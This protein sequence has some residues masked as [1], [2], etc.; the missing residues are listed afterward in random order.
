M[1]LPNSTALQRVLNPVVNL[2]P[3][4]NEFL[5][6]KN[7]R[8]HICNLIS[9]CKFPTVLLRVCNRW[10]FTIV[11]QPDFRYIININICNWCAT[12]LQ[13]LLCNCLHR[14]QK[15]SLKSEVWKIKFSSMSAVINVVSNLK[16]LFK[17]PSHYPPP[18][19]HPWPSIF[20]RWWPI[21]NYC[22]NSTIK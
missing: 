2:Q 7:L 10:K 14:L 13:P 12:A 15:Q 6:V 20:S 11:L 4:C 9:G 17:N 3:H 8:S 19:C 18:H 21:F 16:T 22:I 1:Q 5:T